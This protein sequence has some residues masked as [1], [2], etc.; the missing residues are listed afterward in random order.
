M[1]SAPRAL[2]DFQSQMSF[3]N[4]AAGFGVPPMMARAARREC[5]SG[6]RRAP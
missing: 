3:A 5:V 6:D 1:R 4:A 2:I